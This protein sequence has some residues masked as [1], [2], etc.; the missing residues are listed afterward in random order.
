MKIAVVLLMMALMLSVT[1][2]HLYSQ[3]LSIPEDGTYFATGNV[4]INSNE[5]ESEVLLVVIKIDKAFEYYQDWNQNGIMEDDEW[6]SMRGM[7]V[8]N[9]TSTA[10]SARS[11]KGPHLL[12]YKDEIGKYMLR[13]SEDR[14]TVIFEMEPMQ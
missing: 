9:L 13:S 5:S 1:G 10:F 2:G 3:A 4:I 7:K 11:I 6:E 14:I 8:V 12:F